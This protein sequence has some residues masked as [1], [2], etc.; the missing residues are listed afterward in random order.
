MSTSLLR[1]SVKDFRF[2]RFALR[3]L[4]GM[5]KGKEYI[6]TSAAEVSVGTAESNTLVLTDPTVSGFHFVVTVDPQGV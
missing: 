1:G 5:D 2:H 3:V 4:D 6:C